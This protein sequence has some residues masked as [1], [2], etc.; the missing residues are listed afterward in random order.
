MAWFPPW[1]SGLCVTVLVV[2]VTV[3]GCGGKPIS[4]A[5]QISDQAACTTI[6]GYFY[7]PTVPATGVTVSL[8]TAK[9]VE[10]LLRSSHAAELRAQAAPLQRAIDNDDAA[11]LVTIFN[12]LSQNI[13]STLGVTPPT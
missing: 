8:T 6:D 7:Y 5:S 2:G 10:S 1:R 12:T 4:K 13:C 3:G 9:R 11:K